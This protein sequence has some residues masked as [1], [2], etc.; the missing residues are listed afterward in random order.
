MAHVVSAVHTKLW[1]AS[2]VN[3][4]FIFDRLSYWLNVI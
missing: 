4:L 3:V 1:T 2:N